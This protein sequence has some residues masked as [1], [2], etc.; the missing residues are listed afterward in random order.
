[1]AMRGRLTTDESKGLPFYLSYFEKA[2]D[3]NKDS[4]WLV[5]DSITI[6]DLCL[7]RITFWISLGVLDGIPSDLF[8]SYPAVKKHHDAIESLPEIVS[9][10]EKYPTPYP[11][12][13]Y[14]PEDI[15]K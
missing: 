11:D 1:M 14:V 2:L 12:F 15:S 6:A 13:D 8:H 7:H 9:F 10:R 3:D 4:N 5:G